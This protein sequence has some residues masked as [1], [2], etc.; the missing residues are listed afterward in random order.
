[1][2]KMAGLW[3]DHRMASIVL[4]TDDKEESRIIESN[5]EKQGGRF[6]HVRSTTKYEAQLVPADDSRERDFTGHLNRYYDEI[7]SS[8]HH[9]E[10]IFIFGPGEPKGE[11]IKRLEKSG[12]DECVVGVETVDKMTV[13]QISAKVRN[14]FKEHKVAGMKLSVE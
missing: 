9:A 7:I 4:I 13:R 6:K 8:L 3:I 5:V 12:L 1:M 2:K 14:Y 10:A 11:L